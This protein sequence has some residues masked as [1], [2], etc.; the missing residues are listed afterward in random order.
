MISLKL[1]VD[2][3][4]SFWSSARKKVRKAPANIVWTVK[5]YANLAILFAKL[6]WTFRDYYGFL[7]RGTKAGNGGYAGYMNKLVSGR[8]MAEKRKK[9]LMN[10]EDLFLHMFIESLKAEGTTLRE[11]IEVP[12]ALLALWYCEP[13]KKSNPE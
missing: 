12:V 1:I 7:R 4:S 8:V 13:T 10:R 9:A 5:L 6:A 11:E 2:R 3:F